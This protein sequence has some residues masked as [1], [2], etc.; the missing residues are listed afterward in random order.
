MGKILLISCG[1]LLGHKP[2]HGLHKSCHGLSMV[3]MGRQQ[4]L[5]GL[6]LTSNSLPTVQPPDPGIFHTNRKSRQFC[7]LHRLDQEPSDP[8][9]VRK[10][11]ILDRGCSAVC[12]AR[13]KHGRHDLHCPIRYPLDPVLQYSHVPSTH[14]DQHWSWFQLRCLDHI[15]HWHSK[16]KCQAVYRPAWLYFCCVRPG[17]LPQSGR[18]IEAYQGVLLQAQCRGRDVVGCNICG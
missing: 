12:C 4:K 8:F 6:T 10:Q 16:R 5:T 17:L 2:R 11:G 3:Q 14:V 13:C 7:W 15:S 1:V 18:S 9:H